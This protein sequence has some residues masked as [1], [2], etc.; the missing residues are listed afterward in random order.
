MADLR[1]LGLTILA[2]L[3]Q[4][5][6]D[7][8]F[9]LAVDRPFVAELLEDFPDIDILDQIKALRWYNADAPPPNLATYRS[10]IRRWLS[11]ARKR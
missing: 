9:D 1:T 5:M 3:D 10:T 8:P 4:R 2:Y 6:P 11:S 7:Y